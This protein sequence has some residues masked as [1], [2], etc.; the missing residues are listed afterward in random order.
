M[1]R[2]DSTQAISSL[3]SRIAGRYDL[4]NAILS[5]G[6]CYYWRYKLFQT[7]KAKDNLPYDIALDLCTGTG[8]LA[9]GISKISKNY[10]LSDICQ[11]MLDLVAEK[12][13]PH[14]VKADAQALPFS[15]NSF[16]LVTVAYGVRNF[17]DLDCGLTEIHR[18]LKVN[19]Q[20]AILEF[21]QPSS[22]FFSSLY[23]FYSKY[24]LPRLGEILT[25]DRSAYLYL[26][27]SSSTFPCGEKFC[28]ILN[29]HKLV[30]IKTLKLSFGIAYIYLA[31]R[32]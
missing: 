18:I 29:Q 13:Q 23:H 9:D 26:N 19:G 4:A 27:R 12:H 6:I 1:S 25:G 11:E 17:S 10:T 3:F 14:I 28:E 8:A 5:C 31:V 20:V 22:R 7:I 16:D 30:P 2:I 32:R 21:G 15:D 24:I